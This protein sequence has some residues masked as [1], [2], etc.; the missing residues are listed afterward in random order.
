M[1]TTQITQP[2]QGL[3]PTIA[4]F[5]NLGARLLIAAIFVLSGLNKISQYEGTQGYM[6][7]M[8]VPGMMLPLVILLEVV[9]GLAIIVGYQ[10]RI[11]AF[12]LAGFSLVSAVMFHGNLADQMQMIHFMKNLAMAGGLLLIV[13][14]GAGALSLD[15]RRGE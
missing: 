11:A 13:V 7:M 6:E 3:T 14:N 8:G 4:P 10:A 1:M 12:L 2:T 5:I 9:A 15:N